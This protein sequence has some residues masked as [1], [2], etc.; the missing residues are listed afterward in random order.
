MHEKIALE[1]LAKNGIPSIWLL[2]LK[3]ARAYR[4]GYPRTAEILIKTADEAER[5]LRRLCYRGAL[6]KLL[7][8][9]GCYPP[10]RRHPRRR[11]RRG[12]SPLIGADEDD[13]LRRMS[14]IR[15]ELIDPII[16]THRGRLVETT[17]DGLLAEFSGG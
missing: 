11:R 17:G 5:W 3:A 12:Y 10:S 7:N 4:D 15:A 1:P 9:H 2:H 16:A 14:A 8:E 6:K 13:T